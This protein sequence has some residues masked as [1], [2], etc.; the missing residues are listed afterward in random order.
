MFSLLG[1]EEVRHL[2]EKTQNVTESAICNC[3][4]LRIVHYASIIIKLEYGMTICG[5]HTTHR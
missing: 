4:M 2:T 3:H 5:V 1:T